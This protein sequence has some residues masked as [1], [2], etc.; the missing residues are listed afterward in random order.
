MTMKRQEEI[1]TDIF[2]RLLRYFSLPYKNLTIKEKYLTDTFGFI[3]SEILTF[4]F[5]FDVL[6][7][8]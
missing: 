7:I 6:Q 4:N 8:D 1:L 5:N 2:A 3:I